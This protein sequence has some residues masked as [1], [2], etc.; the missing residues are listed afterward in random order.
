M[1]SKPSALINL[2]HLQH[3]MATVKKISPSS[4][5][6]AVVKANAYGHGVHEVT[7]ALTLADGFAVARF[8]EA[9]ELRRTETKKPLLILGGVYTNNELDSCLQHSIQVTVHQVEQLQLL[10]QHK[11]TWRNKINVWLK[12]DTGMHRLGIAPEKFKS[13]YEQLCALP[14]VNSVVAM[15]HF[16]NAE[17]QNNTH[18]QS[19]INYF[20]TTINALS[21]TKVQCSLANSAAILNWPASHCD[22][23]RP[24][25]MLYGINPT[26]GIKIDLKPVMT[27]Q[28]PIVSI[29]QVTIGE[30]VGYN[31]TWKAVRESKIA[32]VALGYGD[33]YPAQLK[34][35]TPV[36]INGN[37]A[38]IVGRVSMD[39]IT[40]DCTELHNAKTGDI[41][42]FWG[43]DSAGNKLPV[44]EISRQ[45][46]TIPYDLV[47]K[48]SGRVKYSY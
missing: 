9:I 48:V 25:L 44:E 29:R 22:W 31:L 7:R 39:L 24:G 3:N 2:N 40:V 41:V 20:N 19:Q 11:T 1:F 14:F 17:E 45:A 27:L 26:P 42:T 4:K 43:E 38:V 6:L 5:L 23:I 10:C 16:A 35:N 13:F 46:N 36:L 37:R 32:T 30:S 34:P 33:G 47:T 15:T 28:A 21:G 18:T 12:L 8:D